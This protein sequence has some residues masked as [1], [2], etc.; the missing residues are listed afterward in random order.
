MGRDL[1]FWR[2]DIIS[3]FEVCCRVAFEIEE[4]KTDEP[5]DL[6][7]PTVAQAIRRHVIDFLLADWMSLD[8][9]PNESDFISATGESFWHT[10]DDTNGDLK[11]FKLETGHKIEGTL[12]HWNILPYIDEA[13]LDDD[14]HRHPELI[15]KHLRHFG[16]HLVLDHPLLTDEQGAPV[17]IIPERIYL[18]I[19][20]ERAQ[21]KRYSHR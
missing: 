14:A 5:L 12:A 1:S 3:R 20:Y 4:A 17:P 2:R 21:L 15:T 6:T 19:H 16:L 9:S 13:G 11:T 10:L 18:P 8:D 7:D